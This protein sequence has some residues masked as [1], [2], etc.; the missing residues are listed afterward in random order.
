MV[1]VAVQVE[2]LPLRSVTVSVT[3]FGP[4]SEQS[5]VL[6]D[7]AMLW[8]PQLSDEPLSICAAVMVAV[9]PAFNCTVI[10]WQ[11]AV[12]G[13]VSCTVTVAPQVA[14]LPLRSVTVSVTAF[15]PMSEQSNALGDTVMLWI[16]QLS[17][18]PL[19]I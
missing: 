19:S 11:M 8:M 12:G 16:P 15:A 3:V 18:E 6:G 2:T 17:N 1:T 4:M 13:I 9:P 5:K 14:T 7:T 10:F